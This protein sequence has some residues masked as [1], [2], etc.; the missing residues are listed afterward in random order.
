[1]MKKLLF[2]VPLLFLAV[3]ALALTASF[4]FYQEDL[5]QAFSDIS[6]QFNVPIVVDQ[7]VSGKVTANLNDVTLKEAMDLLCKKADL[8]YFER[9]GVY[10]VGSSSSSVMMKMYG[11]ET[12][13]IPLKYLN[14]QGAVSFLTNYSQ[15]ISYSSNEPLLLFNGPKEAYNDILKRLNE[16]D[17]KTSQIYV[18]YSIYKL[19]N[20]AWQNGGHN[21]RILGEVLQNLNGFKSINFNEFFRE[22]KHFELKSS[23]FAMISI[24]KI[25]DFKVQDLNTEIKIH[26]ISSNFNQITLKVSLS[27]TASSL[28]NVESTVKISKGKVGITKVKVGKNKFVVEINAVKT[29]ASISE[30]SNMW[31]EKEEENNSYFLMRG[32]LSC[33]IFNIVGRYKNFAFG[34][35]KTSFFQFLTVYGGISEDFTQNLQGY[36]LIGVTIPSTLNSFSSYKLKFIIVQKANYS[37][38]FISS[39]YASVE[40]PLND[41]PNF[42]ITYVGNLEYKIDSLFAGGSVRYTYDKNGQTFTPFL[43]AGLIFNENLKGRFLYSPFKE[44]FK[45]EI[46]FEM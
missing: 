7:S 26:V 14:A 6:M 16:V 41:L 32:M 30:L 21:L 46:D 28:S 36:A 31:P 24:G 25:A 13:V 15:Y 8:F 1:M 39:G 43:S 12:Q 19:S 18:V 3:S 23:G 45:G 20:D 40:M 42:R 44:I 35:E 5:S 17:V 2:V 10:F 38:S 29:S 4:S 9:N 22:S 37:S 33:P 34:A 11:Y 27:N